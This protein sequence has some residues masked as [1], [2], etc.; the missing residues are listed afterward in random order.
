VEDGRVR[1]EAAQAVFIDHALQLAALDQPPLHL[2]VPDALPDFRQFRQW[3]CHRKTSVDPS[4]RSGAKH[5]SG[6]GGEKIANVPPIGMIRAK[7][8]KPTDTVAEIISRAIDLTARGHYAAA[9]PIFATVYKHI[10]PERYPQGLSGYGLCL[11]RIERKNKL[12][13]ELCERAMALEPGDG[14]H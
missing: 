10:A 8:V 4:L 11:S 13:V 9:L 2:V 1:G 5:I 6:R 12:G 14:S 7:A 3:I